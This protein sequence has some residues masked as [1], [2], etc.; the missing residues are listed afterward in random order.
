PN[1]AKLTARGRH[2]IWKI[3]KEDPSPKSDLVTWEKTELTLMSDGSLLRRRVVKFKPGPYDQGKPRH[4]DYG[5][6]EW[7]KV[8]AGGRPQRLLDNLKAEGYSVL[9]TPGLATFDASAYAK[10]ATKG[11]ADREKAREKRKV[12][13]AA[14]VAPGGKDGPGFYVRNRYLSEM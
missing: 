9:S 1:M 3:S 13:A 5:W 6:K 8:K 10:K 4:H 2:E 12:A 7:K 14:A 11:K